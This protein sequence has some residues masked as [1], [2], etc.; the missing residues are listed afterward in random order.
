MRS[1][2]RS[3]NRISQSPVLPWMLLAPLLLAP[4]AGEA[5]SEKS[6]ELHQAI[7]AQDRFRV[8]SLL[9]ESADL[10]EQDAFDRTPLFLASRVGD[11]E[12][13]RELLRRGAEVDT[14][15]LGGMTALHV[16]AARGHE[17]VAR[18][19]VMNCAAIEA[20]DQA[21][22]TPLHLA[23][24]RG[25]SGISTL[26]L[27]AGADIGTRLRSGL[28]PFGVAIAHRE[29]DTIRL[30]RSRLPTIPVVEDPALTGEEGEA[31]QESQEAVPEVATAPP[32]PERPRGTEG[33]TRFLQ[34]KLNELGYDA[35]P[36]NGRRS[37]QLLEAVRAY[38]SSVGVVRPS[39][40][41]KI[42][43]CL[44]D[45][46]SVDGRDREARASGRGTAERR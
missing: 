21:R 34:E 41:G 46:I 40:L 16:A 31:S 14:P 2:S 4:R 22:R 17:E 30:L 19:L 24:A 25:H 12:L 13:V 8:E 15:N 11:A 35:G 27:D 37:G 28:T 3:R 45:R 5:S 1:R 10:E 39:E 20:R 36:V 42:S 23:A 43:R 26:L 38:Q 7:E 33:T 32:E 9:S 6:P 18:L 44:V 29:P